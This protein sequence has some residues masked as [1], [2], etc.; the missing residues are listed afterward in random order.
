MLDDGKD[1]FNAM[2]E[3]EHSPPAA[4]DLFTLASAPMPILIAAL[5]RA[6]AA[7]ESRRDLPAR[8]VQLAEAV[9]AEAIRLVRLGTRQEIADAAV[10]TTQLMITP[11]AKGLRESNPQAHSILTSASRALTAAASPAS[12]GGELTVLRSWNGKAR[13]VVRHVNEAEGHAVPRAELRRLLQV[14]ESYLSHLLADLEASGL[15]ERIR[16]GRTVTVHLGRVALADHVQ[17]LLGASSDDG[18]GVDDDRRSRAD[19]VRRVANGTLERLFGEDE[20]CVSATG[21]D[22][23]PLQPLRQKLL[24]LRQYAEECEQTI[25]ETVVEDGVAVCRIRVVGRLLDVGS[26][27]EPFDVRLVCRIRVEGQDVVAAEWWSADD[28]WPAPRP[29]FAFD[30]PRSS[31]ILGDERVEELTNLPDDMPSRYSVVA[32]TAIGRATSFGSY[33]PAFVNESPEAEITL[34]R[35]DVTTLRSLMHSGTPRR[36]LG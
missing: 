29:R 34:R 32:V 10:A 18:S 23:G 24:G 3:S 11:A 8:V 16:E 28:E 13:R 36:S 12:K 4:D 17:E 26:R 2:T 5:Q 7:G 19:D 15:V 14:D 22:D 1:P 31:S 33:A 30:E 21:F 6:I 25:M 20:W 9:L 35:Y 27:D